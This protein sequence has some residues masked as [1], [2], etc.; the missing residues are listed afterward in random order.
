MRQTTSIP[1][2]LI[3]LA[4]LCS[5]CAVLYFGYFTMEAYKHDNLAGVLA[6][7]G[8]ASIALYVLFT[9]PHTTK[10]PRIETVIQ[11]QER[12]IR[13]T[14][15]EPKQGFEVFTPS[16]KGSKYFLAP[17][18]QY[19]YLIQDVSATGLCK[20]GMSNDVNRRV[21]ELRTSS[22]FK[23]EV[24]HIVRTN[25]MRKLEKQLHMTHAA[26][27]VRGEWFALSPDDI[28]YIKAL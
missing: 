11:V 25:D 1:K 26:K 15:A 16:E 10:P 6:A 23:I 18:A 3:W 22:P 17:P 24:V 14:V 4:Y 7:G 13:E 8:Y 19:V 2:W 5:A 27:C 28:A 20:I 12:I 9:L 21:M